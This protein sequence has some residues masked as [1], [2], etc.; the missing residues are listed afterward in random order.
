[1]SN[2]PENLVP[3]YLRRMDAKLDRALDQIAEA[4]LPQNDTHRAVLAPRRVR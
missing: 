4:K 2:E 3:V 1:M